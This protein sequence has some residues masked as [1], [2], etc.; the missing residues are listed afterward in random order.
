MGTRDRWIIAQ[1][2]RDVLFAHWRVPAEGLRPHVP[3]ALGID[4][5]AGDAWI[6]VVPF[7]V[8]DAR[9]RWLPSVPRLSSFLEINVRTY[10]T[11]PAGPAVWFMSLDASQ[12]LAVLAARWGYRLPYAHARMAFVENR[13]WRGFVST[14]SDRNAPMA[15]FRARYR[16]V[17]LVNTTAPRTLDHWLTE[18]LALY[19][20]DD[21]GRLRLTTIRHAPWPLQPAEAD[22]VENTMA[23]PF[24]IGLAGQPLLH[25][26]R[27]L[28]VLIRPPRKLARRPVPPTPTS[29]APTAPPSEADQDQTMARGSTIEWT[30]TPD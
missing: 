24:G 2:W 30:T 21:G 19:T 4:T 29:P 25:F 7:A 1:S 17:G 3:D 23:E 15:S 10:V 27:R 28:D 9:L 6:G 8:R 13:D 12:S 11:G 5:F 20:V 18:R 26:A 14:R 16:P 22:I